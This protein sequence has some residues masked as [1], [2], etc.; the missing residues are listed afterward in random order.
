MPRN[1]A[2]Y[3][4]DFFAWTKEQADLLR[5][6]EFAR[7]DIENVAEE[8]EDMGRSIRREL[9]NRLSILTMHLLKWQY[10]PD[11]A[12]GVGRRRLEQIPAK[13]NRR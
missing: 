2:A 8:L 11:T 4:N 3:D 12:R 13:S 5:A 6:G 9:R 1:A 7:L 10:R